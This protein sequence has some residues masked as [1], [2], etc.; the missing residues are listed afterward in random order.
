MLNSPCIFCLS[1]TLKGLRSFAFF[2]FFKFRKTFW[3]EKNSTTLTNYLTSSKSVWLTGAAQ[4]K[5]IHFLAWILKGSISFHVFPWWLQKFA[6]NLLYPLTKTQYEEHCQWLINI[7][8]TRL[9]SFF[10]VETWAFKQLKGLAYP[11]K[12]CGA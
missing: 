12:L 3:K 11:R 8:K 4:E 7:N 9:M 6:L 10:K 2:F 5:Y 1:S